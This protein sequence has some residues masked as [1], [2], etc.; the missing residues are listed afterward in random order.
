MR[1][2]LTLLKARS[3]A[4][5]PSLLRAVGVLRFEI[6]VSRR[7]LVPNRPLLERTIVPLTARR[8]LWTPLR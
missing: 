1:P 8:S 7:P 4:L 6:L 3:G 2:P 5:L